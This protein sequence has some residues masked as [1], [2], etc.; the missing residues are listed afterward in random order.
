MALASGAGGR[1]VW[2]TTSEVG[3]GS[4]CEARV[5]L[6]E[7]WRA[8]VALFAKATMACDLALELAH[9]QLGQVRPLAIHHP[10]PASGHLVQWPR[11][12]GPGWSLGGSRR[13]LLGALLT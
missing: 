7:L 6:E 13:G 4:S 9:E 12:M 2:V 8:Q 10:C 11:K 5:T 3:N 1:L